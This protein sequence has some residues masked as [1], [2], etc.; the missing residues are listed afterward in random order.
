M[1]SIYSAYLFDLPQFDIYILNFQ[2]YSNKDQ[3]KEFL[4]FI[5]FIFKIKQ[6]L[7]N[8]KKKADKYKTFI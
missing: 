1:F 5:G 6:I 2:F 3:G 4:H 7:I 8:F